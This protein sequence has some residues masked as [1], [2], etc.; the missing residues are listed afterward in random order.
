MTN[1][2]L[3][4]FLASS[5]PELLPLLCQLRSWDGFNWAPE[6]QK[7]LFLHITWL[8]SFCWTYLLVVEQ[9]TETKLY[10]LKWSNTDATRI[11]HISIIFLNFNS[12]GMRIPPQKGWTKIACY[13][14]Q[15][16]RMAQHLAGH[17]NGPMVAQP[18]TT[19]PSHPWSPV[20]P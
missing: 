4:F 11:F 17:M 6:F 3:C 8:C 18:I 2:W 10:S 7:G 20:G 19:F 14:I 1:D 16:S 12:A 5:G 15:L 13:V 9:T